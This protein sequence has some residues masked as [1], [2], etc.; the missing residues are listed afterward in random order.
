MRCLLIFLLVVFLQRANAQK[1]VQVAGSTVSTKST[2]ATLDVAAS[3]QNT[4]IIPFNRVGNLIIIQATADTSTG[5]FILDT[6][7]PGLVLNLTY[8]RQYPLTDAEDRGS[9]S[10]AV[11]G[12]VQTTVHKFSFGTSSFKMLNADMISLGHIEDKRGIK[13][14]G[15]IGVSFFKGCEMIIDY[16]QSLIHLHQINKKESST[17]KSKLLDSANYNILDFDVIDNKIIAYVKLGERKMK[18]FIDTGAES[19]ILDSR[20]P[21]KVF[22]SMTITGRTK[23]VGTSNKIVEALYGNLKNIKVGN[24]ELLPLPFVITNLESACISEVCCID[25][26][27]GFNFLAGHKVGFNFVKRQMYLWK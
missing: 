13:I 25:G 8:F 22:E 3:K 7:A 24:S 18:F 12:A 14:L 11:T 27:L 1:I 16:E 10:G 2:N 21:N 17:Y 15:L 9:V 4:Q 6:G 5:N 19:N 20:L 23:V 26:I